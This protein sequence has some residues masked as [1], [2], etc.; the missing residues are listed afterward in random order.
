MA[1]VD[2]KRSA[3]GTKRLKKK[4]TRVD[5]TPMVDLGFLLITFFVFTTR[6]SEAKVMGL[7]EP[8]EKTTFNDLVCS[9]CVLTVFLDDK[10]R[11]SY[12]EGMPESGPAVKQTTFTVNGIRRVLLEKKEK[13]RMALGN[14]DC[15]VLIIKPGKRSTMQN[16]V[17]MMDEVAINDI[18]HYYISETDET[19]KKLFGKE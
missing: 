18:V 12:Y 10:N 15:F 19:D 16:F 14:T 13:V 4:S 2:I 11:I 9:S 6:L 17:D 8:I 3:P 1:E 7:N 5:L